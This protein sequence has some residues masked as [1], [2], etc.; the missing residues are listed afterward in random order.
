[1]NKESLQALSRNAAIA[2]KV[3]DLCGNQLRELQ[4]LYGT[5]QKIVVMRNIDQILRTICLSALR[6]FGSHERLVSIY[7][8]YEADNRIARKFSRG[9][10]RKYNGDTQVRLEQNAFYE[11]VVNRRKRVF[12]P[13]I[14]IGPKFRPSSPDIKSA[15]VVPILINSP[16]NGFVV[17]ESE[18]EDD[19]GDAEFR[20][21]KGLA[22]QAGIA[23]EN[24]MLKKELAQ[25]QTAFELAAIE[26][27]FAEIAHDIRNVS[28]MISG[29]TQW[30][31]KNQKD[32]VVSFAE[33]E[34]AALKIEA[35]V[36]RIETLA[37]PADHMH[38]LPPVLKPVDIGDLLN[39]AIALVETS[40]HEDG[41]RIR[42]I[43]R[44]VKTKMPADGHRLVRAFFNILKNAVDASPP[45]GAIK[46]SVMQ[47]ENEFVVQ[48]VDSGKGIDEE[49]QH[50]I[51]TPLFTTKTTGSGLGLSLTRRIIER[52]HGGSLSVESN[53]GA[54][55][56]VCVSLPI[57]P[58][59][60]REEK[61]I[62]PI[63]SMPGQTDVGGLKVQ[64]KH[65]LVVNDETDLL[66]RIQ[67]TLQDSGFMTTG[68]E[69]GA[70]A[71][72][73]C[74]KKRYD[75]VL[76][77]FDLKK[78]TSENRNASDFLPEIRNLLP[79]TPI[80]ITSAS[81]SKNE[82]PRKNYNSFLEINSTFWTQL[83]CIVDDF[84][85]NSAKGA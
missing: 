36:K 37:N 76:M 10:K 43:Q 70:E 58:Q 13:D 24:A 80:I 39:E 32:G 83:S 64:H 63:V 18:I 57:K 8:L 3:A 51:F 19:F 44:G 66:Q 45:G 1:M 35:Q 71:V 50:K 72:K 33:V 27:A 14:S 26:E 2:I 84:L 59:K 65:I 17:M 54:G 40:A 29:E 21:L 31:V 6:A 69:R 46:I 81:V 20:L 42:L 16:A 62:D 68:M 49:I 47:T 4:V 48:F 78:D 23:I 77:D 5:G 28:T 11:L 41:I 38:K 56:T 15:L 61:L 74:K 55:T 7:L 30:L 22:D 53:L 75:L 73:L 79:E 25:T 85:H 60:K 9:F 82:L 67:H 34:A 52:D 12:I